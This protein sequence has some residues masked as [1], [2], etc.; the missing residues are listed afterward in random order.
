MTFVVPVSSFNWYACGR[1]TDRPSSWS[2]D[3][4]FSAAVS[5]D[6][7]ITVNHVCGLLLR[8]RFSSNIDLQSVETSLFVRWTRPI[9]LVVRVLN[10]RTAS[11]VRAFF[12]SARAVAFIF[13]PVC[14][15]F[16]QFCAGVHTNCLKHLPRPIDGLSAE[17]KN[18][19]MVVVVPEMRVEWLTSPAGCSEKKLWALFPILKEP[20][21]CWVL[22]VSRPEANRLCAVFVPSGSHTSV[23]KLSQMTYKCV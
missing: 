21:K 13:F 10:R 14:F 20:E 23:W 22:I 9:V 2:T 12:V 18:Y 17:I 19:V 3:D 15:C 1:V 5:T 8:H 6:I 4:L 7:I 16:A 11:V